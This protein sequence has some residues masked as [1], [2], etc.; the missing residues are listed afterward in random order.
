MLKFKSRMNDRDSGYPSLSRVE[1]GD[2]H[3]QSAERR[4]YISASLKLE[5]FTIKN[6]NHE[7]S[8]P[9]ALTRNLCAGDRRTGVRAPPIPA[10]DLRSPQT[11]VWL[12]DFG[13][14]CEPQIRQ[15]ASW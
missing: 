14:Q 11:L 8:A 13:E 15:E 2:V 1:T 3:S 7:G 9:L 5:E 6:Q 4:K 10:E 12:G